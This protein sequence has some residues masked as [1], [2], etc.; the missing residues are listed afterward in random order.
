MPAA[1]QHGVIVIL[2]RGRR[3]TRPQRSFLKAAGALESA[4]SSLQGPREAGLH[5]LGILTAGPGKVDELLATLDQSDLQGAIVVPDGPVRA[6]PGGDYARGY[7]DGVAD[8]I[9]RLG[10]AETGDMFRA[11]GE[12]PPIRPTADNTWA[13][14]AVGADRCRFTG[15]GVRLAILDSGIAPDHP[16]FVG[17]SHTHRN[18]H[19]DPN[20]NDE[21]GHG[22]H[23]AG[24]IAGPVRS[25]K[26]PRYGI[27]P[28]V[29]LYI[30][31]VL[32]QN[33]QGLRSSVLGGLEWAIESKCSIACLALGWADTSP[34]VIAAFE[35]IGSRCLDQGL[36]VVAAAGNESS[37]PDA[38]EEVSLPANA[39]SIMAVAAVDDRMRMYFRSNRGGLVAGGEVD[40]AAPGVLVH[41]STLSSGYAEDSGTSM[42][43]ACVAGVAAL[44]KEAEPGLTGRSLWR[45][46]TETTRR[47]S[48]PAQ[49]VGAGLVQAPS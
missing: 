46:V 6:Y 44:W 12:E 40:V 14:L 19:L 27:A 43:T 5:R 21:N 42:A 34:E 15:A 23:V 16:D 24:T 47:L 10:S 45:R 3:A 29:S 18:F 25:A 8:A 22:T 17:R 32:G 20:H 2:P 31:K 7:R 9:R 38:L 28:E 26:G 48:H 41:S 37:R 39:P 33:R 4:A 35:E 13:R 30:G 49:D 11:A 1:F 36:L